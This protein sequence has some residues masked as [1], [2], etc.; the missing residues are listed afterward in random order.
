MRQLEENVTDKLEE[1][2]LAANGKLQYSTVYLEVANVLAD[3]KTKDEKKEGEGTEEEAIEK[4]MLDKGVEPFSVQAMSEDEV[5]NKLVYSSIGVGYKDKKEEIIPRIMP[6]TSMSSNTNW[7]A[8]STNSRA[9]RL[10]WW[11][12]WRRAKPS[13]SI[14]RPR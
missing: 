9:R 14:P 4:R 3:E 1:L 5:T 2:R 13:R 8:P 10:R 7:S 12:W 6:R 11:R